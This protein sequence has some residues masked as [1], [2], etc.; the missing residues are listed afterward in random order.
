MAEAAAGCS[1]TKRCQGRAR[2]ARGSWVLVVSFIG[3]FRKNDEPI[4]TP[5][6]WIGIT[7]SLDGLIVDRMSGP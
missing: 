4:F 7:V 6:E 1:S 2:L 5:G 3:G